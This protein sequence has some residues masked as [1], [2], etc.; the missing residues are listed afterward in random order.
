MWCGKN[1]PTIKINKKM[2]DIVNCNDLSYFLYV[3]DFAQQTNASREIPV[4]R[5]LLCPR[6]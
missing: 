6:E 1:T 5:L 2:L 4:F 3:A